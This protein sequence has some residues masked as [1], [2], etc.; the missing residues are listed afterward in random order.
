MQKLLLLLIFVCCL[1]FVHAQ[2]DF[3]ILKKKSR[4]IHTYFP[5]NY[6]TFITHNDQWVTGEIKSIRNDSII[7]K[8]MQIGM[9]ANYWGF[10]ERDTAFAGYMF[11]HKNDIIAFP[12]EK[13]GA[14]IF[15]NGTL[16][17][18]AGTGYATVNIANGII[19]KEALFD[20]QNSKRLAT[21]AGLFLLG[22]ILQWNYSSVLK[23]GKKY[24]LNYISVATDST[25]KHEKR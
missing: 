7:L 12:R 16:L 4:I 21:A 5:G 25:N 17:Q 3:L 2:T 6:I 11:L 24:Q 9:R 18:L 8:L 14:A 13:N 23:I 10:A 1:Q 15:T 20:E 22:K 19:K